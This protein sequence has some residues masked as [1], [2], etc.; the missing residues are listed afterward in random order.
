MRKFYL[1]SIITFLTFISA[2]KKDTSIGADLLPPSDL[3]NVKFT[4]SF[5][6]QAKTLADTFLRT[7]KL[8]KNF[9]GVINDPLFGFQKATVAIEL[10]RPNVVYDDTLGPFTL[11]SVVLFLK[12]NALYGD[13]L[14][15]Q[16]FT[17]SA[18]NNKIIETNSYYSNTTSFSGAGTLGTLNNYLFRPSNKE[19]FV[20]TDTIGVA[21]VLRVKLNSFVGYSILNLGQN[22]LRD[23]SQFKN[24][25]PGLFI[26]NSSN[27]GKLMA[28][29]NLASVN[30]YLSLFYKD[31]YGALKESRMQPNILGIVNGVFSTRQNAVNIFSNTL[32]S[33]VQTVISSGNTSDSVNYLLGQGGTTLRVSLPTISGLGKVAV[34]KAELIMTQVLQNSSTALQV[35]QFFVLLERNSSGQLDALSTGDG[36]GLLDTTLSD[37]S[38]NKIA[39]YNFDVSQY[40]QEISKGAKSPSD[41]YVATYR[42]GGTSGTVNLLNSTVNG[43]V[44]NF[45]Y[46]PSR[47]ILAGPNYSDPRY[48][49]KLNMTYTL[50]K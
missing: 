3:L 40:I 2:C 9:L 4:D 45:S 42:S 18:L 22:I 5:T 21:G 6:V 34:N 29:L 11:D 7:D 26:E 30:S 46:S 36:I 47:V 10:D 16:S 41:L 8:A 23:S 13:S 38:G 19:T 27:A 1:L 39:V 32:S 20:P 28:E 49:M 50:I 12:Y 25:F 33:T 15:P 31:K 17:V 37:L 24:A 43:S 44:V 35:P 48:R 14:V